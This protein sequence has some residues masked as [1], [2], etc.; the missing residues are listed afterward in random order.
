METVVE[1]G[2]RLRARDEITVSVELETG[3]RR[4]EGRTLKTCLQFFP[5]SFSRLSSISIT[6]TKS[7]LGRVRESGQRA[8]GGWAGIEGVVE[9][10]EDSLVVRELGDLVHL[11]P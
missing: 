11:R 1:Q 5:L 3:T 7:L 2:Q 4:N 10:G 6:S 9:G 8:G